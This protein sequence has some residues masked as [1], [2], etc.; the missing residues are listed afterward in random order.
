MIKQE[1]RLLLSPVDFD[2]KIDE[3]YITAKDRR[4]DRFAV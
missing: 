1:A 2:A 3:P 4:T